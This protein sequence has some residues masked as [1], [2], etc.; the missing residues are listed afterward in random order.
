MKLVPVTAAQVAALSSGETNGRPVA[1]GW[2]HDD[3]AAGLSFVHN[4]GWQFLVVDDDGRIAGECGTK[5][6]PRGGVVEIGYGLAAPS[7]GRGLGTAAVS[8]LVDWLVA[9]DDVTVIEAEVHTS[10]EPSR[11]LVERLGFLASDAPDQGYLRYR[12]DAE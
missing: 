7:R 4:G 5:T 3:T 6:A 2:P 11:R 10:N 12:R 8:E 9:R 1:P